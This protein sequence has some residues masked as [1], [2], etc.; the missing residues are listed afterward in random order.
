MVVGA[1]AAG[2]VET[3]CR[4][5][6]GRVDCDMETM[7][8]FGLVITGHA[9]AGDVVDSYIRTSTSTR[10][11]RTPAGSSTV[12][13]TSDNTVILVVRIVNRES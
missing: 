6:D 5:A 12:R 7:R 9:T 10:Y 3:T 11:S 13:T 8:W 1:Y 4:R 2:G